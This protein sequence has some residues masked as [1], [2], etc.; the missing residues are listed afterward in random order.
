MEQE[1]SKPDL[2]VVL[3]MVILIITLIIGYFV[4]KDIVLNKDNESSVD[5]DDDAT[6]YD[7]TNSLELLTISNSISE[8][9]EI[10]LEEYLY[11]IGIAE[12]SPEE[13]LIE[14]NLL[15]DQEFQTLHQNNLVQISGINYIKTNIRYETFKNKL[16]HY[17]TENLLDTKF[18]NFKNYNGYVAIIDSKTT[19]TIYKIESIELISYTDT[20]YTFTIEFSNTTDN[21][22][23]V[24][25][26][27]LDN[28]FVISDISI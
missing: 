18:S 24:T 15:T 19:N 23:T 22:P 12:G 7:S 9:C 27:K 17:V 16:L 6:S 5:L 14:L 11:L 2:S 28:K 10:L 1:S 26:T 13:L 4:Y 3:L 20:S 25:F 8:E 21:K